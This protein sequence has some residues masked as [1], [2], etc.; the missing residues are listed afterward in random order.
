[1]ITEWVADEDTPG[2]LALGMDEVREEAAA[3]E[4]SSACAILTIDSILG[5]LTEGVVQVVEEESGHA[6]GSMASEVGEGEGLYETGW[7]AIAVVVVVYT[8]V[9]VP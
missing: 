7:V 5:K 1:L 2:S 3:E 4:G 9:V 8:V 6:V